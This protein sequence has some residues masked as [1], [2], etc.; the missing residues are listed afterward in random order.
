[1][2]NFI[3]DNG[4]E[5]PL[6]DTLTGEVAMMLPRYGV[7]GDLGR[8]KPEVVETSNDLQ[9]LLNKYKLTETDVYKIGKQA[10][11]ATKLGVTI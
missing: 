5:Q 8:G 2:Q 6:K 7:W 3:T 9:Y 4:S 1:M 11:W 10:T